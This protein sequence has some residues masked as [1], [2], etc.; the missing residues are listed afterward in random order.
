M[1]DGPSLLKTM[2]AAVELHQQHHRLT[3]VPSAVPD[4][5]PLAK[6]YSVLGMVN[7]QGGRAPPLT[8]MKR[9]NPKEEQ[10]SSQFETLLK[11][12]VNAIENDQLESAERL[13][14]KADKMVDASS[15]H[16]HYHYSNNGNGADD[17]D[18]EDE[19]GWDDGYSKA[20]RSFVSPSDPHS[21][22]PDDDE[23][24]DMDGTHVKKASEHYDV[25]GGSEKLPPPK[26]TPTSAGGRGD[27]YALGAPT[28]ATRTAQAHKFDRLV[29]HVQDRDG[30][31][32]NEAMATARR[33]YPD[34]YTAYQDFVAG[35]PTS[36][37]HSRRGAARGIG[38]SMPDTFEDL[39]ATE[40]AKGVPWRVAETRVINQYGS[41]ALNHRMIKR[42][43]PSVATEFTKRA[44]QILWDTPNIDRCEA[45]RRLRKERPDWYDALNNS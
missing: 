19:D 42:A 40:M 13:L 20:K 34:V 11:A 23:D 4:A 8:L 6:E 29:E 27:T 2:A 38:K 10:M 9:I 25:L 15:V 3:A 31:S 21:D 22:E 16:H 45:L 7:N 35:S 33:E 44:D 39:V 18:D 30:C 43:G 14:S 41:T 36:E 1:S 37:Q 5:V 28:D 32:K 26:P 24:D 17:D 12:A